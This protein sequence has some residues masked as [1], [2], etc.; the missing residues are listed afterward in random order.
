MPRCSF[1][2]VCL[3]GFIV[4]FGHLTD[5]KLVEQQNNLAV[6]SEHLNQRCVQR[7]TFPCEDFI[8]NISA[9][10]WLAIFKVYLD[11]MAKKKSK[12]NSSHI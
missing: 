10:F 5:V 1:R 6:L 2:L 11:Y 8:N 9:L 7:G 12:L 3:D 4:V